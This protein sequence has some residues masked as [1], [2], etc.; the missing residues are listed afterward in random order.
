MEPDSRSR[1]EAIMADRSPET[2]LPL[3]LRLF[4]GLNGITL[5]LEGLGLMYIINSRVEIPIPFLPTYG[6]LAFLPYSFKPLYGYLSQ[7]MTSRFQLFTSL[8]LANAVSLLAT[9]FIPKGGVILACVVAFLRGVT[10]S[11]AE[12]CLGLTLID[13]AQAQSMTDSLRFDAVVSEFQAQSATSRNCGSFL[14]YGCTFIMFTG[15]QF[16]YTSTS[17]ELDSTDAHILL[18]S[19]ASLQLAG[20]A[21]ASF[22]RD[23]FMVPRGISQGLSLL[24]QDRD[25]GDSEEGLVVDET[26]SLRDEENSY[27]S[28]SSSNDDVDDSFLETQPRFL[29]SASWPFR[30]NCALVVLLQITVLTLAMQR[31]IIEISSHLLWKVSVMSC[32]IAT[33]LVGYASIYGKLWAASHSAGLYLILKHALPS[34][35]MVLGAYFY[36]L[37]Q[38][39]PGL[40]QG[41]ALLGSGITTLSSWLYG[42]YLSKY[43]SGGKFLMLIAATTILA[44][45][46]SL[47]NV[48][49]FRCGQSEYLVWI[50]VFVKSLEAFFA[51]WEFLP[52]T[53]L[54]AT[55]LTDHQTPNAINLCTDEPING[56]VGV[57]YG[58]LISCI[59]FGDQLGQLVSGPLVV[60]LGIS[61]EN[62]F[63]QL[64]HL[65]FVCFYFEILSLLL[66]LLLKNKR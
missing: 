42:R 47:G 21:L 9:L 4:F 37:F 27:S 13:C 26:S 51:E 17:S 40:L 62:N 65:I 23:I 66:L 46:A 2:S 39:S 56:N 30:Y 22:H 34:D 11:W 25:Y 31:P 7:R 64:D 60:F 44:S 12:L 41:L 32:L 52:D 35:S 20:V 33:V 5:G 10:D 1:E 59:D 50:V 15:R 38:S 58:T 3:Y 48:I 45:A 54:A 61:R 8:L 14:A 49:I 55:S 24:Q 16:L 6:A 36:S 63:A 53:V 18:I 57:K 29:Q 19:S 43:N 28:C